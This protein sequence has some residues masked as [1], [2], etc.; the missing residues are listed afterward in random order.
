MAE[1]LHVCPF[2]FLDLS[3]GIER[4]CEIASK[5]SGML[6]VFLVNQQPLTCT[7]NQGMLG[8]LSKLVC[9]AS[10]ISN[11]RLS[12]N[13]Q[14]DHGVPDCRLSIEFISLRMGATRLVKFNFSV[15]HTPF[16]MIKAM[17]LTRGT[18]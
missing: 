15:G 2:V 8:V 10:A 17:L 18:G 7:L 1:G 13:L 5:K 9:F 14:S 11:D 6:I 12:Y 3:F 4:A 16:D